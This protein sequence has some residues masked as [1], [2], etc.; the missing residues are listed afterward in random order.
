MQ[1]GRALWEPSA[2]RAIRAALLFFD[3][4]LYTDDEMVRLG[5]SQK[6]GQRMGHMSMQGAQ[7]SLAAFGAAAIARKVYIHINN[8]N[9]VLVDG[10]LERVTVERAG[11]DVAHDGMEI[12]L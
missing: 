8:S 2:G 9:P 5:L 6:T 12:V 1:A 10:S 7:G 4:T 11:W 3:G